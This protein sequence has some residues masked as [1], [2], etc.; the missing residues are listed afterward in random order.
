MQTIEQTSDYIIY[1]FGNNSE[2]DIVIGN[3]M[4]F[5]LYH[6]HCAIWC[7]HKQDFVLLV[8]PT[9]QLSNFKNINELEKALKFIRSKLFYFE[10]V[11]C[12]WLHHVYKSTPTTFDFHFSINMTDQHWFNNLIKLYTQK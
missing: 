9:L 12:S 10:P 1:D 5:D 6:N 3:P 11:I 7:Q 4:I 8:L 2:L